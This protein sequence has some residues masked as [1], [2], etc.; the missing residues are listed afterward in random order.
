MARQ[1]EFPA[2]EFRPR[3][4]TLISASPD[5]A[6]DPRRGGG[7]KGGSGDRRRNP[8]NSGGG[9]IAINL[10]LVVLVAGL[11]VAGWFLANQQ[12]ML[13]DAEAA[14][15]AAESRLVV[16]EDRLRVTDEVLTDSGA[17]TE[18]KINFW[19]SEIRKL[20]AVSNERNKGWIQDNQKQLKAQTATLTALQSSLDRLTQAVDAQSEALAAAGRLEPQV[21]EVAGRLDG[22][23]KTQRDLVDKVNK[24]R[25]TV[26][27]LQAGLANRV[28]ENEQAVASMDTFRAQI[29]GRL[30]DIERRMSGG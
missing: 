16:L 15:Q 10:V 3:G 30:I 19:E 5:D 4:R 21:E 11:M 7:S 9:S 24:A 26:A 18:D 28:A 25:Q 2:P 23:L 12:Q 29:N 20:W 22:V 14:R 1:P 13:K 17:E 6:A 27:S 8:R